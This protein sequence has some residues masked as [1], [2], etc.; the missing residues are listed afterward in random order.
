M[1]TCPYCGKEHPDDAAV[2]AV[3]RT[4]LDAGTSENNTPAGSQ[5]GDT[6]MTVRKI[7]IVSIIVAVPLAAFTFPFVCG[8]LDLNDGFLFLLFP[9][10]LLGPPVAGIMVVVLMRNVSWLPRI[11]AGI[12]TCAV[13]FGSLFVNPPW[14]ISRTLGFAENFRLTKHP[15]RIQRWAIGVLDRYEKGTLATTTNAEYWAVG[16]EKLYDDEIPAFIENLWPKEPSIGIATM[17]SSGPASNPIGTNSMDFTALS[18][19]SL[20]RT[21][22]VAFSWYLTG[23]LIGRADFRPTWKPWYIH[24]VM[25]GIY[26]FHG[27]K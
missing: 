22:C 24:E 16:R 17:A 4:P 9:I 20:H 21:H 27:Y 14:A 3:D 2:C 12:M 23:I 25:P 5:A 19:A 10:L 7:C 15:A 11:M 1:K 18:A 8:F 13:L 26:V 6:G